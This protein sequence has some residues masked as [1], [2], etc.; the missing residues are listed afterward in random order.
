MIE[1][2]RF[3]GEVHPLSAA[4]IQG[5]EVRGDIGDAHGRAQA[6]HNTVHEQVRHGFKVS[7]RCPPDAF[8]DVD[9][10]RA[11]LGTG[12]TIAAQRRFRIER[13]EVLLGI[14]QLRDLIEGP[15]ARG[16]AAPV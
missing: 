5:Y 3:L 14:L 1:P 13:K 8:A 15:C 4:G 2:R 10:L 16:T 9:R 7:E 11:R 12:I 6:A